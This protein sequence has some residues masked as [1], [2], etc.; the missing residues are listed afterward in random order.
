MR[1]LHA[2]GD[3][4]LEGRAEKGRQGGRQSSLRALR[5]FADRAVRDRQDKR[6][7]D[8]WR[9][10]RP[11][12]HGARLRDLQTGG[13]VDPRQPVERRHHAARTP[14]AAGHQRSIPG[15]H[16]AGRVVLG[17]AARARRRNHAGQTRR[18]RGGGEEIRPLHQDHRRPADRYVWRPR[19]RP[20]GHLGRAGRR[21]IR[22]R[23]RL[24]QGAANRE[25]LR[26]HD[27]VPLWRAR[28]GRLRDSRREPLQGHPRAAQDQ[29]GGLRLHSRMCRGAEQRRRPDRHRTG[30]QPVRLRQRRLEAAARRSAWPPISTKKRPSNTSTAS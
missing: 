12:R 11:L 23:A 26:R 10:D 29:D 5:V 8:V 27:L 7:A 13:R 19:A 18:D 28:L 6:A 2:A 25:E 22:K 14:N 1:R 30:I 17:R 16:A 24:R 21:R 3:R 15:Q 20:A 4:S 9:S